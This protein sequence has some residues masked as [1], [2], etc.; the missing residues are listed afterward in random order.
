MEKIIVNASK[1]YD[2]LIGKG[3]LAQAGALSRA[4]L[5]GR[6]IALIADSNV[7]GLYLKP[8]R[9]AFVQAGFEVLPFIF[10]A[11]EQSKRIAEYAGILS[12]LAQNGFARSD[13]VA[14]LGGGVTGDLAGFAAATYMRGIQFVQLPTTLLAMADSSVGG[15]T[16]I[17]LPE[18]KNLAG[19]FWQPSLTVADAALLASLPET[20]IQ[21]G[22]AEIIKAGVLAGGELWDLLQNGGKFTDENVIARAIRLKRDIVEADEFECGKRRLLNLGHTAAHAIE[23]LSDY[24]IPHGAAV[25]K[26]LALI[27][28]AG[29]RRG[30]TGADTRGAVL[31]QLERAGLDTSPTFP[32]KDIARACAGDKKSAGGRIALIVAR[33]IGDCRAEE[34]PLGG[35][36]EFFNA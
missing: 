36:E 33:G 23:L 2:I 7:A 29:V 35:L 26:G 27:L 30:L 24:T 3:L 18:G 9:E 12:F 1:K 34:M 4:V 16:G 22:A 20:E 11:G 21:N 8:A 32:I 31:K 5:N 13:A 14:A 15:K 17:D 25:A 28:G 6:K 19:A 10:P